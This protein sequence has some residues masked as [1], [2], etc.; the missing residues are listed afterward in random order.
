MIRKLIFSW[1]LPLLISIPSVAGEWNR[2][3]VKGEKVE[4]YGR[5]RHF[6]LRHL[7]L[8]LDLDVR[9]KKLSGISSMTF[10]PLR[11]G[12]GRVIVDAVGL[13]IKRVTVDGTPASFE[14]TEEGLVVKI[15]PRPV[16]TSFAVAVHYQG[17][18]S[19]GIFFVGPDRGYPKT[20]YQAW[21]QGQSEDSRYWFPVYDF[22]NDLATSETI[23]RVDPDFTVISNGE[24]K[25]KKKVGKQR[26]FHFRQ[27]VPHATYLVSI[28]AG[29]FDVIEE[30][31]GKIPLAYYVPKGKGKRARDIFGRT[32]AMMKYFEEFI[33]EPYPYPGY[34]QVVVEDFIF[35]GMENTTATTL[36]AFVLYPKQET[37]AWIKRVDSLIAHELAHQWFGDLLTSESWN[38]AW[39][40]EG[41]STY[42]AALSFEKIAGHDEFLIHMDHYAHAARSHDRT[43]PTVL[44]HGTDTGGF[45]GVNVYQRG[46]WVL[47]M[48]RHQLGEELFERGLKAYVKTY[49][50]KTVTTDDFRRTMERTTGVDLQEFFK[51][52]I[53]AGGFLDLKASWKWEARAKA[54]VIKVEQK[55]IVGLK[56]VYYRLDLP[57][58]IQTQNKVLKKV[59]PL[60]ESHAELFVPLDER[61]VT[62][63]IDPEHWWLKELEFKRS[64]DE[65]VG[66]LDPGKPML[67]RLDAVRALA[68]DR[69]RPSIKALGKT[70][71]KDPFW[72]V[73][74][75]A[76]QSLG[77][78]LLPAAWDELIRSFRQPS[79]QVRMAA[80]DGLRQ[81]DRPET[82]RFLEKI[83]NTDPSDRVVANAAYALAAEKREQ[84]FKLLKSLLKLSSHE[85]EIQA[86]VLRGFGDS[87]WE[88][89][90]P[91][92]K[93]MAKYGK[94]KHARA[95]AMY[96]I[97]K[98]GREAKE[99]REFVNFLTPYA[100]DPLIRVR[101]AVLSA[102]GI[103]GDRRAI[104][105]LTLAAQNEAVA[106]TRQAARDALGKIGEG[107]SSDPKI[108]K[109]E[110]K[111]SEMEKEQ[112]A[113]ERRI[114]FLEKV[115]Q[116]PA[117]KPKKK[118]TKR[119]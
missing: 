27:S 55:P 24:L 65:L 81:D 9:G 48:L 77:E 37:E 84:S 119:K 18:P 93:K 104:P 50:E 96:A 21:T 11:S 35:G 31:A 103:L 3:P 45:F 43:L 111:L 102:F 92:A 33:G 15:T 32:P 51:K 60:H 87:A 1:F 63:R 101:S 4:Q 94:P 42:L 5:T 91:L 118:G 95:A 67:V 110:R 62:I 13:E 57:V 107:D 71:R 100:R 64:A 116:T 75:A 30:H 46:A 112:K 74:R 98:I 99:K 8:D 89:G 78:L 28:V 86:K 58:E 25:G 29:T 26:E 16:G 117:P 38:H 82:V 72:A 85:D 73:R 44:Y 10:A 54:A 68:D 40:N 108:R 20:P 90:L 47:H 115:G 14:R 23:V 97:A 83:A 113:L 22:P 41:F 12:A 7:R 79:P 17:A 2:Y 109:L 61:P 59:I 6:D 70:L 106:Q 56:N 69:S 114:E 39:L 52:W 105:T 80:V 34:A 19:K 66:E 49:R 76:A 88:K 36:N 53:Y